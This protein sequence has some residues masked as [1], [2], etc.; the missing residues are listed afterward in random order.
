MKPLTK[1][2]IYDYVRIAKKLGYSKEIIER[3]RKAT[4]IPEANRAMH[5]GR[6]AL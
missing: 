5:D 1:K 3:L 4:T 2:E 6:E